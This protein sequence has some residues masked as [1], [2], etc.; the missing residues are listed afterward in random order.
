MTSDLSP[1]NDSLITICFICRARGDWSYVLS[2]HR[3]N[4]PALFSVS[5]RTRY[6]SSR[7]ARIIF[8][9][10]TESRKSSSNSFKQILSHHFLS[11]RQIRGGLGRTQIKLCVRKI[12]LRLEGKERYWLLLSTERRWIYEDVQTG[13]V[14]T[15][16]L[17]VL[18]RT[19]PTSHG[20]HI[21][22]R[23]PQGSTDTMTSPSMPCR[24]TW[25]FFLQ[26]NITCKVK[27]IIASPCWRT[28]MKD[29]LRN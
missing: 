5:F 15:L 2:R 22:F 27:D 19:G 13:H 23:R 7:G 24:V 17:W 29:P 21:V 8:E 18:S 1:W 4:I 3:S 14:S 28:D 11:K 16:L 6:E 12:S 10:S 25:R 26:C 20:K 9:T